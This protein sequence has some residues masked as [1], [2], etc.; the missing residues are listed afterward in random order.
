MIEGFARTTRHHTT[1]QR[2][3]EKCASIDS[4]HVSVRDE[5]FD[6]TDGAPTA[7]SPSYDVYEVTPRTAFGLPVGETFGPTRWRFGQS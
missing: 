3:A 6:D 1:L 2:V 7:G 4:W 5:A